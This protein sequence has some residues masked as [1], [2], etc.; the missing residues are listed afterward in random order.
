MSSTATPAAYEISKLT[1]LR[2]KGY[3]NGLFPTVPFTV[4]KSLLIFKMAM[5]RT[6]FFE[7]EKKDWFEHSPDGNMA[8]LLTPAA[9][10]KLA[11]LAA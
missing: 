8:G 2:A 10:T 11:K 1:A 6:V 9:A 3:S 4:E 7:L 5:G